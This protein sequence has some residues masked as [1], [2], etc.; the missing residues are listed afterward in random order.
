MHDRFTMAGQ[1]AVTH[2]ITGIIMSLQPWNTV[3]PAAAGRLAPSSRSPWAISRE[4]CPIFYELPQDID[5][6]AKIPE[7]FGG[8]SQ[9]TVLL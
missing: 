8:E 6:R 2:G 4:C 7:H 1:E 5:L 9:T 3:H